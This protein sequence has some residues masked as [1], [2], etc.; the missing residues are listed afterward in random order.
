MV[1]VSRTWLRLSLVASILMAFA[2][3]TGV[4]VPAVYAKETTSWAA[5]GAGQ[6]LVNLLI[7]FPLLLVS[8]WY[9]GRGSVRG[10]LIWFGA[11]IYV[12]YSYVTYAFFV[13][14]GPIFLIYVAT[15]GSSAYALAGATTNVEL[16]RLRHHWPATFR[17]RSVSVF[18]IFVGVAF[19]GMWLAAIA[20][21]LMSGAAPEGV[22][23]SGLPV[24]PIHVLDLA[25]LLPLTILT[26]IAHWKGRAFGVVFATPLLVFFILMDA[27]IISM[28]YFM[29]ARG[30]SASLGVVPV[31]AA[32]LV[33]SVV[34]TVVMMRGVRPTDADA[35]TSL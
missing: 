19:G 35:R 27:A 3:A 17:V 32:A 20:R 1:R 22:A 28:T 11:L 26:G 4:F 31:M 15:L 16:E 14:F 29:R 30:V 21:A 25:F 6:D 23:E 18:L 10:L 33:I 34:L 8:T 5:Q 2:S 12:V 24:N 7:V 13:H 9:V